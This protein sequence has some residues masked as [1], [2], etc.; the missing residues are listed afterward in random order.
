VAI[1]S[2]GFQVRPLGWEV[3]VEGPGSLVIVAEVLA[4]LD[5]ISLFKRY[6]Q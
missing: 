5:D 4:T 2:S 6:M 3:V 1:P